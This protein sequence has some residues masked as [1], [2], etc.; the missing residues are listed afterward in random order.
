M[1]AMK[2]KN[3]WAAAGSGIE[4]QRSDLFW[5]Q[6]TFPSGV[7]ADVSG[8]VNLWDEHCRFAVRDFP[9]PNRDRESIPIKYL[10]QTNFQVGADTAQAPVQMNMRYAFSQRTASLLERWH[11]L[12]ANPKTGGVGLST[13]IKTDGVFYWLAPNKN[14][15]DAT[16]EPDDLFTPIKAYKLEGCW[17]KGLKPSNANIEATNEVV[18]LEFTLQIDRYYPETPESL[19]LVINPP[20][21]SIVPYSF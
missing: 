20:P 10:Q 18:S 5:I 16:G 19:Q 12:T 3:R 21:G 13:R 2:F 15:V 4:Q 17:V 9:F 1:P 7:V 14:D 11:W 6:L 8:G